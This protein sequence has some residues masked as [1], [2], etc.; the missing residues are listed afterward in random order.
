[1]EMETSIQTPK[2]WVATYRIEFFQPGTRH[3]FIHSKLGIQAN[4]LPSSFTHRFLNWV[5]I[6]IYFAHGWYGM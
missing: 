5:L 2:F 6:A 3:G 4:D 1:M